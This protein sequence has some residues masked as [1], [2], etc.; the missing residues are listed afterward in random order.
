MNSEKNINREGDVVLV[1]H[2]DKP[3][4][5]ARIEAIMPDIKK[6]WFQVTLLLL[7]L[8]AQIATWILRDEYINGAPFTME[9]KAM[10][11]EKVN[12]IKVERESNKE[13]QTPENKRKD[14]P[15]QVIPFKKSER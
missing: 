4:L 12:R 6:D 11:L 9:G 13:V 2:E 8:P 14:K 1:H 15:G 3:A 5:Y 10:R 7:T